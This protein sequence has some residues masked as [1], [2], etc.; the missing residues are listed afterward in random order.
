MCSS[1]LVARGVLIE[2]IH[3]V[4]NNQG[5]EIDKRHLK[6]AADAITFSG[7]V[8]GVTRGGIISLKDSIISRAAFETPIPQFVSATMSGEKDNLRGVIENIV[9][10]QPVPIGTDRKSTRLN[11]SHTDISRMP[12]SA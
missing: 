4:L 7:E 8:K 12:S 10:N 5:L 11:S 6:L 3:S 2:E 9:L 1:D